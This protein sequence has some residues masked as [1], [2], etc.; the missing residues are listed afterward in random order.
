MFS[1]A[2]EYGIR[3]IL[4]IARSSMAGERV[5]LKDI[6]AAIDS[7]EAFTAKVLQ[8]LVRANAITSIKG[9][10]GGFE[11]TAHQLEVVRLAHIVTAIDGDKLFRGC[12][13][14]LKVCNELKP[15]P[16][17]HR[18]KIVRAELQDML[19]TTSIQ[20]MVLDLKKGRAFLK[21]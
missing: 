14:G 16:V 1:K 9:P 3:A 8:A 4:H 18:F 15:C 13:L 20:E 2:C 10:L 6:A 11:M 21:V 7:P 19:E 17:H 5:G 12:G